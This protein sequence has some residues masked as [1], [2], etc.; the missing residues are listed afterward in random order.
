MN[1]GRMELFIDEQD[2]EDPLT[3]TEASL[4][5]CAASLYL[6]KASRCDVWEDQY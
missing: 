1:D 3:A 5:A 4:S 6:P 2:F